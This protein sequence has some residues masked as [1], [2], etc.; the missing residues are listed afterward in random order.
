MLKKEKTQVSVVGLGYVGLP[1]AI[2]LKKKRYIVKGII[3]NP[4]KAEAISKGICPFTD[5]R[6]VEDLKRHPIETSTVFDEVSNSKIVI[7]CV[8]TPVK[9]NYYP[10]YKPVISATKNVAKFLKK[11]TLVILESTVNP[12]TMETVVIPRLEKISGLKAGK[13][14]F[15]SHCPERINPGDD[16]WNVE[17]IPR[18]VGSYDRKGLNRTLALYKSILKGKVTPM[19]SLREAEAVKIV[20]NCFRDINIAFV[21]ELAMS[22]S[23]LNIDVVNVINGA[24]TK[25]FAF[26][27]HLPGCGVGGHCIPVDPY[28]LINYAN[29]NGFRHDFLKL[30]RKINNNMP[31]YT[32][33]L[34]KKGMAKQGKDLKKSTIAVL[35]IAYKAGI[36]D[37]RESPTFEILKIFDKQKIKYVVFDPFIPKKSTVKS[38]KEALNRADGVIIATNHKEFGRINPTMLTKNKIGVLIDG[39]NFL[40][41]TIFINSGIYYR[42]IGR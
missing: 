37:H 13:D 11:G 21:N 3:K 35:G 36:D 9:E 33:G 42:G 1:L 23:R 15:V 30:A 19:T 8:P 10:D 18:V 5:K 38:L 12:G 16:Y 39:R 26:L 31:K 20:E 40:N 14:F 41:K 7:I 17:N 4:D 32:I 6:H 2:L 34:L 25:P 29:K 27:K 22:F 24:N 28:Y